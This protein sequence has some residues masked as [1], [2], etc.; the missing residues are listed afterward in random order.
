MGYF[1]HRNI[2]H[3]LD[4][5]LFDEKS[6]QQKS[7]KKYKACQ[8]AQMYIL[9]NLNNFKTYYGCVAL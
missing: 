8:T 4:V 5:A 3:V 6:I 1:K 2:M 9:C 7:N